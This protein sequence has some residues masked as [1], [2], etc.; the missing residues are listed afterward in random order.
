MRIG[1]TTPSNAIS[2]RPGSL[3]RRESSACGG[4]E[5]PNPIAKAIM[6]HCPYPWR[7]WADGATMWR[8]SGAAKRGAYQSRADRASRRAVGQC[9][10]QQEVGNWGRYFGAKPRAVEDA[11]MSDTG[12]QPMGLAVRRDIDAQTV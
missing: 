9:H 4:M 8:R 7:D 6:P 11:V 12:L 2:I 1:N 10:P 5:H 3:G